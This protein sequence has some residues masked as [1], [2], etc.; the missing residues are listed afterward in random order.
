MIRIGLGTHG[1]LINL[2]GARKLTTH[3]S[4]IKKPIDHYTGDSQH[5]NVYAVSPR[6]IRLDSIFNKQSNIKEE[7]LQ[8][9]NSHNGHLHKKMS[10][11]HKL[12][13]ESLRP[14][15]QLLNYIKLCFDQLIPLK[16][17]L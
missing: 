8:M 15:K 6:T 11:I 9:E 5:I 4:I 7:R 17:Y 16:E 14:I 13:R 3:L 1:Y 12:Q 2:K 10:L